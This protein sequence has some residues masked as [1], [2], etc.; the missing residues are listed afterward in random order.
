MVRI[1]ASKKSTKNSPEVQEIKRVPIIVDDSSELPSAEVLKTLKPTSE[2][3]VTNVQIPLE[4][5]KPSVPKNKSFQRISVKLIEFSKWKLID[6][7]N[8]KL[9][10]GINPSNVHTWIVENGYN[11]NQNLIYRN[12]A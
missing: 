4:I 1:M 10:N 9:D 2:N 3:I 7:V 8:S 12:A 6:E 11:I 5:Q